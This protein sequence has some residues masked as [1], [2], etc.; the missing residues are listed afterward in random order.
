MNELR[1][2]LSI[3]AVSA[4]L[5]TI[6]CRPPAQNTAPATLPDNIKAVFDKPA[7]KGATWGLRVVD[8]TTGQA[9]IDTEPTRK[10]FIG[11][12]RKVFT[13]GELMNQVGPTHT[14]DTP[15]YRLGAIT[16]EGVLQ[17]DLVHSS[18]FRP[19]A[20]PVQEIGQAPGNQP[21]IAR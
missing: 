13:V 20:A 4:I 6:G 12:V 16:P 19:T 1:R 17:G 21:R 3:L 8:L 7:Y 2:R 11:S 14:Y 9:L 18:P 5:S 15:V 10:F